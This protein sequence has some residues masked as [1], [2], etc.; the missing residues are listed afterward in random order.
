MLWWK[1][2]TSALENVFGHSFDDG[3]TLALALLNAFAMA[4][5]TKLP[6]QD[7]VLYAHEVG[8]MREIRYTIDPFGISVSLIVSVRLTDGNR[9]HG[10]S[11]P[12]QLCIYCDQLLNKGQAAVILLD[13]LG[14]VDRQYF[15]NKLGCEY[16][17]PAPG[18]AL[19]VGYMFPENRLNRVYAIE[20][21]GARFA[22]LVHEIKEFAQDVSL[23]LETHLRCERRRS[24]AERKADWDER[25]LKKHV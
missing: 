3:G 17:P 13:Q 8:W 15:E 14:I 21:P 11:C 20:E 6:P 23:Y 19:T 25:L 9:F 7:G 24:F 16:L 4:S 5:M 22:Y 2:K 18:N 10:L 12:L 1:K